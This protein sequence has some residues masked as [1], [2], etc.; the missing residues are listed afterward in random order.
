MVKNTLK[1]NIFVISPKSLFA[2]L[3]GRDIQTHTDTW[4][5]RHTLKHICLSDLKGRPQLWVLNCIQS[6]KT[7][8]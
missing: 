3:L 5:H 7:T 1:K 6:D 4:I 2:Q 8:H